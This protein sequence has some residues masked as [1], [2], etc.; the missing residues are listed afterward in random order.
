VAE[1]ITNLKNLSARDQEYRNAMAASSDAL[2]CA[3]IRE[4]KSMGA[5]RG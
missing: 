5:L 1:H 2:L 3:M 4:L